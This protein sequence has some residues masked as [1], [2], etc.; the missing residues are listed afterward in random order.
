MKRKI[1][2]ILQQGEIDCGPACIASILKYYGKHVSISRIRSLAG[3][4]SLGTTGYGM[5]SC[6]KKFGFVS[7][8]LTLKTSEDVSN[9]MI[10]PYI[11]CVNAEGNHHH[12]VVIYG[13]RKDKLIIGDPAKGIKKMG[14]SS[15]MT[16]F[17]GKVLI[18]RKD[19]NKFNEVKDDMLFNQLV[20]IFLKSFRWKFVSISFLSILLSIFSVGISLFYKFL[21]DYIIPSGKIMFLCYFSIV[22][23]F[24]FIIKACLDFS[25]QKLIFL[26]VHDIDLEL[27]KKTFGNLLK[28]NETFYLNYKSGEILSIIQDSQEI[29]NLLSNTMINCILDLTIILTCFILMFQFPWLFLL[30]L[31]E[32]VIVY[33]ISKLF[34]SMIVKNN[35]NIMALNA[36]YH[37]SLIEA[38]NGH[39]FIKS[40]NLFTWI[41][42]KMINI[43]KKYVDYATKF[44]ASLSVQF[45]LQDWIKQFFN[46]MILFYGAYVVINGNSSIGEIIMLQTLLNYLITS[47]TNI[48][49]TVPSYKAAEVS[50][51]RLTAILNSEKEDYNTGYQPDLTF[52]QI[53][54]HNV[55]FGYSHSRKLLF[56]NLSFNISGY[57]KVAIVGATGT[58]KTTMMKLLQKFYK[59][60]SGEI[61]I[62]GIDVNSINIQYLRN[63]I[64]YV[65]QS[66]FLFNLSILE[67]IRLGN[68]NAEKI[69]IIELCKNLGMHDWI[70]SLPEKYDTIIKENGKRLSGGQRQKIAIIQ[71]LIKKPK[72]LIFD[73]ATS[74]LDAFSEKQVNDLILSLKDI[75]VILITHRI[76]SVVDSDEII[77]MNKG[78]VGAVGNHKTLLNECIGYRKMWEMQNH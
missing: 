48:M 8:V 64:G 4:D 9:L 69:E 30:V 20:A 6:L 19:D 67:N 66:P 36:S 47:F 65:S 55:V 57:K 73:E 75:L 68:Q 78:E 1:K 43:Y 34:E 70:E 41:N 56:D 16:I 45:I 2:V 3:T 29:R 5:I 53:D 14:L 22:L 63:H 33:F 42:K 71:A 76:S 15:Y 37:V 49:K 44:G 23:I 24:T 35:R 39:E 27:A 38:T 11:A 28:A 26:L 21:Y 18:M 52:K 58:G 32:A 59:P 50:Y 46:S 25:R 54:F 7:K 74:N 62:D 61:L 17:T 12:Y 60:L 10:F 31:L 13:M 40:Y 51:E 77:Y 72:L